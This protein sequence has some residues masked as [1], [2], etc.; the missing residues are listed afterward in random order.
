M[1]LETISNKLHTLLHLVVD[2]HDVLK[3]LDKLVNDMVL[4]EGND[5]FKKGD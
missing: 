1:S 5:N 4:E 3:K 2:L